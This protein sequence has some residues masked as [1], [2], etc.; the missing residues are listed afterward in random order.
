MPG[1][2]NRCSR[3]KVIADEHERCGGKKGDDYGKGNFYNMCED[4]VSIGGKQKK[5]LQ[6]LQRAIKSKNENRLSDEGRRN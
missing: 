3:H 6:E 5:P 1:M 4:Y 2:P